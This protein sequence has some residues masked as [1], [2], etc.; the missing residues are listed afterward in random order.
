VPG[1]GRPPQR[2]AVL[3]HVAVGTRTLADGWE[4]FGG[5]LGGAWAYGG[6]SPGFWWGQLQFSAGAKVELLT[7]TGGPDA[8]FLER[9]LDGRGPGVHH[10]N[11]IVPAIEETL[12]RFRALG[13][14]PVRVNLQNPAWKE[15]FLMPVDAFG[16]VV[17][18]AEQAGAPPPTTPPAGLGEPAEP[19]SLS[20][21]EHRVADIDGAVRLFHEALDG[22]IVGRDNGAS[23]SF[24]ELAW[25]NG[26]RLRLVQA[27][28][29]GGDG[30]PAADGIAALHF[31]RDR[32]ELSTAAALQAH[33]L[34]SR[35]GVSLQLGN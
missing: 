29:D 25:D 21:V 3:D 28:P 8:A 13:I 6:D 16:T 19:C 11:F 27:G 20:Y 2:A 5:L 33:Q 30:A 24:A 12:W 1:E 15:A 7:P 4:L 23:H 34:A 14:E 35:L 31:R 32:G 17:Q 22:E 9:F 10:L 26:A 18:V